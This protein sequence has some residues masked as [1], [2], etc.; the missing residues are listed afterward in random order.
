MRLKK[1]LYCLLLLLLS[2]QQANGGCFDYDFDGDF[3]GIFP[4][5]LVQTDDYYDFLMT[6]N[7]AA[8]SD[9]NAYD[10]YGNDLEKENR[11]VQYYTENIREWA[12]YLQITKEQAYYLVMR[13]PKESV[14]SLQIFFKSPN[15]RLN[16]ANVKFCKKNHDALV[17]ISY[18]KFLEPFMACQNLRDDDL[19][20][21]AYSWYGPKSVRSLDCQNILQTLE[22]MYARQGDKALKLRYAYQIVRLQHYMGAYLDAVKSF[23]KYVEPLKLK[24]EIYYYALNQ[25]AGAVRAL[26][27]YADED[28]EEGDGEGDDNSWK[29]V[30][31]YL[32]KIKADYGADFLTVFANS[33]DL[34][35][36][37][38]WS[39]KVTGE[40]ERL[41]DEIPS[42]KKEDRISLYFI[43]G[44]Q[45]FSN[46]V[47]ELKKIVELNPNSEAA[48][49]LMV[50]Y[51]NGFERDVH[52]TDSINNYYSCLRSCHI[53]GVPLENCNNAI[54]I[55]E[56]M[57][58]Q[59]DDKNFWRMA[60]AALNAFA[61]N[62]ATASRYLL[63]VNKKDPLYSETKDVLALYIDVMK[64]DKMTL[65]VADSIYSAHKKMFPKDWYFSRSKLDKD[66]CYYAK[67]DHCFIQRL[68]AAKFAEAGDSVSAFLVGCTNSM[69]NEYYSQSLWDGIAAFVRQPTHNGFER[70]LI[71]ESGNLSFEELDQKRA[72]IHL[73]NA[74]FDEAYKLA[75]P[76]VYVMWKCALCSNIRGFNY[77]D[78]EEDND[79]QYDYIKD[80]LGKHKLDS[81][82]VKEYIGL[83]KKLDGMRKGVNPEVAAKACFLLGNFYYNLSDE[84][85]YRNSLC[86]NMFSDRSTA[87]GYY[88]EG[89]RL[90]HDD[91]L[92]ARL[93]LA[94]AKCAGGEGGEG[95]WFYGQ[96]E[97]EKRWGEEPK[98]N[99]FEGKFY[100]ELKKLSHTK[101]YKTVVSKC[102]YFEYYVN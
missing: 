66:S 76:K 65:S 67:Y 22:D 95:S 54:L 63:A 31:N 78:P 10:F 15:P 40:L 68:W 44:Y 43:L 86:H 70:W 87:S 85:Y 27:P 5:E 45:N 29:E 12:A 61:E 51:I 20:T 38:F 8:Y 56:R 81:I 88:E 49:V 57:V 48:R 55:A 74:E 24:T 99:K 37:V 102:K 101:Y 34:K 39:L 79:F 32:S 69:M 62:Y 71:K 94:S 77:Y 13:A 75:S 84:G 53:D 4:Q 42:L 98:S 82:P 17:Y 16:F 52:Y 46:P 60:A 14:D 90:S 28:G 91:E 73:S 26:Q 93:L 59:A 35:Y 30:E 58:E 19:W 25:K 36:N 96:Y 7:S 64:T 3:Y 100:K 1:L 80:L 50:R 41:F 23:Y 92:K 2:F 97:W 33:H 6:M 83:L 89:L 9:R 47:H 72:M 11:E 18:A 21:Y